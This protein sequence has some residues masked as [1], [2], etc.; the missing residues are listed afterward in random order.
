MPHVSR[1]KLKKKVANELADEFLSFLTT[2]RSKQDAR[3]LL[4]QTE[5][6]MLAKRLSAVLLLARGYP[7]LQIELA[8]GLTRQTTTRLRRALAQ[9]RFNK[10]T[11]Y[12]RAAKAGSLSRGDAFVDLLIQ[13]LTLLARSRFSPNRRKYL[14]ALIYNTTPEV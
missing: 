2:T 3:E 8:L 11:K 9:G 10:V 1:K 14:E 7:S 6:V 5:R 13:K 12:A 4:S